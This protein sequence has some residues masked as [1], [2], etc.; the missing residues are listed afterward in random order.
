ML[1]YLESRGA[2]CSL[3]GAVDAIAEARVVIHQGEPQ[4][5]ARAALAGKPQLLLPAPRAECRHQA[6]RVVA[7][8][9][10]RMVDARRHPIQAMERALRECWS[11]AEQA[12]LSQGRAEELVISA[13]S[14]SPARLE[15]AQA[16]DADRA[17]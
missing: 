17:G 11:S 2:A 10:G 6:E 16:A 15:K 13:H 9:C 5:T 8:G 12:A 7:L 14:W 4:I 1:H 3:R